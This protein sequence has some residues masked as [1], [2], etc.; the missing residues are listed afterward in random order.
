MKIAAQFGLSLPVTQA[1]EK[2]FLLL[3]NEDSEA[4]LEVQR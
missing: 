4:W 2:E 3:P 1:L